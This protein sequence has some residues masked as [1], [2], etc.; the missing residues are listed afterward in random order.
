MT[1]P[2]FEHHPEAAPLPASL[3]AIHSADECYSLLESLDLLGVSRAFLLEE[4]GPMGLSSAAL[5]KLA[6]AVSKRLE[7]RGLSVA[8]CLGL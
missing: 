4:F 5:N 6:K 3:P 7:A 2:H 1:S 8:D